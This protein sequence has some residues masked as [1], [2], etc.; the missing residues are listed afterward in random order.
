M[1]IK[2]QTEYFYVI[3]W[4]CIAY[5]LFCCQIKYSIMKKY[6][7][8]SFLSITLFGVSKATAQEKNAEAAH[9][10]YCD[11]IHKY[12]YLAHYDD[13][14]TS[15]YKCYRAWKKDMKRK[16]KECQAKALES[17][18]PMAARRKKREAERK[19]IKRDKLEQGYTE[20]R[21]GR[22]YWY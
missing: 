16:K 13:Y 1:R 2:V 7:L 10:A 8:I 20:G 6:L 15:D 19:V 17:T 3:T 18:R 4:I 5:Y 11:C 21:E 14:A 12:S 9:A 22:D